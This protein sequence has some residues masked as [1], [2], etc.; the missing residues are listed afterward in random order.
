MAL[1][2]EFMSAGAPAA[3]A[4]RLGFDTPTTGITAVGSSQTTAYVPT[5]NVNNFTTVA[6]NTGVILPLPDGKG[7]W[8]MINN[9]ANALSVYPPVGEAINYGTTNAAVSV[10]AGKGAIFWGVGNLWIGVVSA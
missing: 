9:G 7:P 6:S 5:S 2:S 1:K 4:N 8:V 10:P 3:L